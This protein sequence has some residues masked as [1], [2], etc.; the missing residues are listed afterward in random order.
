MRITPIAFAAPVLIASVL[1]LAGCKSTPTNGADAPDDRPIAPVTPH[2]ATTLEQDLLNVK[3]HLS[4]T[5][6]ALDNVVAVSNTPNLAPAMSEFTREL[7]S[8]RR[9]TDRVI[10]DL[11][12][13]RRQSD[14]FFLDRDRTIA[15]TG[16]PGVLAGREKLGFVGEYI[17]QLRRDYQSLSENFSRIESTLG[18][19]T[20]AA[21]VER[22]KPY[23]QGAHRNR[24]NVENDISV[25]VEEMRRVNFGT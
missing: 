4:T 12:V 25:L 20:T 17:V 14:A 10:A 6:A 8:L 18:T 16:Q 1:V 19:A 11:D 24:I 23:I 21:D 13:Q 9:A 3:P 2:R 22:A 15:T 7:A 5:M